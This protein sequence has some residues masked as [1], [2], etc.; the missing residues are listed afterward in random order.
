MVTGNLRQ[1]RAK[2]LS[3][4]GRNYFDLKKF[5][6]GLICR[7]LQR[8]ESGACPITRDASPKSAFSRPVFT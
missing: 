6:H 1:V 2:I 7:G 3:H 4:A 8:F 5:R